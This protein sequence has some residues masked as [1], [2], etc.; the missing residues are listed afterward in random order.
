MKT[1][2][3]IRILLA[4]DHEMVLDGLTRVLEE[5]TDMQVVATATGGEA[6]LQLARTQV[7]D[8]VLLDVSLPDR[9]G[10]AVAQ[11]LARLCPHVRTIA[12]TRHNDN[13]FVT[14]MLNA[15]A[16]GYVLK[17]SSLNELVRAVRTVAGGGQYI[18][19]A[20]QLPVT[21]ADPPVTPD[22]RRVDALSSEEQEVLRLVALSWSNLLISEKLA[23][24]LTHVAALKQ[25]AMN[26]AGLTTRIDII[27]FARTRGWL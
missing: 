24:D 3:L 20:V 25:A 13:A 26:K 10:V 8:V 23:L 5:Q 2:G 11:D 14:R 9:D 15:G 1:P 21:A 22:A 12:L 6:A 19:A 27:N 16:A 4:D 18:D 7:P 17:Q